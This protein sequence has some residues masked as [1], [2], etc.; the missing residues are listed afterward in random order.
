[1]DLQDGF[2]VGISD[3]CD[4]WCERCA[5]TARC[6]AFVDVAEF[7]ASRDPGLK[8]IVDAPPLPAEAPPPPPAWM[9]EL[10]DEMNR[11]ASEHESRADEHDVRPAPPPERQAISE[12]ASEY[13]MRVHGWMRSRH[14][15][16]RTPAAGAIDVIAWFHTL[17]P[18]KIHRALVGLAE[19]DPESR[20]WPADYDG[21]AKVALLGIEQSH[22]AWLQLLEAGEA[23]V[24]EAQ[25]MIADLVWLG[26]ELERT[27]PR[28]RAFVRPG[29]DEPDALARLLARERR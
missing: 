5:F 27:F 12:R 17:V 6:R 22:V 29:F 3:Y 7:E 26:E 14:R 20:D 13:C 25:V 21:S 2:I 11:A 19:D 8:P 28:A 15:G 16:D 9:Q 18:A 1:M 4:R 23:N 24:A 10:I